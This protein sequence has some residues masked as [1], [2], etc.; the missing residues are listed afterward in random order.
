MQFSTSREK[1]HVTE[2]HNQGL[3]RLLYLA[4]VP[5][6]SSHHGSALM[7]RLL[8]NYPHERLQI[9]E[10]NLSCSTPLRRLPNVKYTGLRYR[11]QRLHQTRFSRFYSSW[12]TR[13][14][15]KLVNQ[16]PPL[17][18]EFKPEAVL[19]IAHGYAWLTA[20]KYAEKNNLPLHLIVHD[21]WPQ[22]VDH[23]QP[24]K[25]WLDEEFGRV[26][27]AAHSRIC[28]SPLMVREYAKRY[29]ANG[30]VLY[31][32]RSNDCP[33]Y[34]NISPRVLTQSTQVVF[35]Y[36]GNNSPAVM[37]GLTD[38]AKCLA[39]LDAKLYVYGPFSEEQQQN[40][41]M[42]S[43]KIIFKGFVSFKEMIEDFRMNADILFVPIS[44]EK[45]GAS[46][47]LGFPSK[48]ADYSAVGL[49]ILIYGPNY[50]S[51]IHWTHEYPGVA[52]VVDKRDLFKLSQALDKLI[53]DKQ[54]RIDLATNA[55]RVGGM[56]FSHNILE[57][58]FFSLLQGVSSKS[59]FLNLQ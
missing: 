50:W 43:R 27:R 44:F 55:L 39:A 46:D 16:V 59:A 34:T 38:L 49:P 45:S 48:L 24:V 36:G 57:D 47:A 13:T 7:Y 42:F 11:C 8:T 58:N 22:I 25:Q 32:S 3:P 33:L 14:A 19:T 17:L 29:G 51:A 21:D 35:G 4:D 41:K 6:E 31:P 52:E 10:S 23:I 15:A 54:T 28:A 30:F 9:I 5:V 2:T 56:C 40:L 53:K 18:E 1:L 12:L 26:Y 37:Q 20:A